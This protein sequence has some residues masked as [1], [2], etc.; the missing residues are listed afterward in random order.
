[1]K[2]LGRVPFILHNYASRC[3]YSLTLG[4]G[5]G[6]CPVKVVTH[7]ETFDQR[8][9]DFIAR[10]LRSWTFIL[11]QMVF[12]GAWILLKH[13]FPAWSFDDSS[14][15]ILRLVLTIEASFTGSVL[16]MSHHRHSEAD[17]KIMYND[18]VL[19]YQI[20]QQIKEI[21]PLIEEMHKKSDIA[22][23]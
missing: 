7:K 13:F 4:E 16:L 11:G 23:K 1:V 8:F 19:D 22:S 2:F 9:A 6:L 10:T 18:Y 21:R 15:N 12:I 3:I 5:G 20:R 17:R 14:Y